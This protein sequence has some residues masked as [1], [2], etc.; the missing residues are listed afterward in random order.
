[1]GALYKTNK[2]YNNIYRGLSGVPGRVD[3]INET[4]SLYILLILGVK[5]TIIIFDQ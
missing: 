4:V 5:Y 3:D 1:M 2:I